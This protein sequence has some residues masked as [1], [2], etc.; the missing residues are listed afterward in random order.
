VDQSLH[1]F[2]RLRTVS[3]GFRS[4]LVPVD[5]RQQDSRGVA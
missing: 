4:G 5:R 2:C 1:R 3:F